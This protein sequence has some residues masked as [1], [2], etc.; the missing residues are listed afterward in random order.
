MESNNIINHYIRIVKREDVEDIGKLKNNTNVVMCVEGPSDYI[1]FE[2]YDNALWQFWNGTP[3]IKYNPELIAEVNRIEMEI[4]SLLSPLY[5]KVDDVN[6]K[7]MTGMQL[8]IGD[9]LFSR[10]NVKKLRYVNLKRNNI[11][12]LPLHGLMF[13]VKFK[14]NNDNIKAVYEKALDK[15]V[16]WAKD[17]SYLK[18]IS[19][20]EYIEEDIA[21]VIIDF[22]TNVNVCILALFMMINDLKIKSE[23]DYVSID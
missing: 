10:S 12:A 23:I 4:Q 9:T 17:I 19:S 15:W 14:K 21:K 1:F 18:S 16:A 20:V 8:F 13:L 22:N 2:Y 5:S 6:Y 7:F 3:D 11:K